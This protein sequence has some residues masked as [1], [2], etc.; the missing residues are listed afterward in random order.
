[1]ELGKPM[2]GALSTYCGQ[3]LSVGRLDNFDHGIAVLNLHNAI[4]CFNQGSGFSCGFDGEDSSRYATRDERLADRHS[5]AF[6]Q[7]YVVFDR[8][9]AVGRAGDLYLRRLCFPQ[10]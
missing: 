1:M 4:C 8:S 2:S 3:L 5:P 10:Q 6:R 7:A 9:G